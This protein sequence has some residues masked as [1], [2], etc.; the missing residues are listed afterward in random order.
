MVAQDSLA[1]SDIMSLFRDLQA[2]GPA[3]STPREASPGPSAELPDRPEPSAAALDGHSELDLLSLQP[4]LPT[5]SLPRTEKPPEWTA[6]T[7][8]ERIMALNP[9]A[10]AHFLSRFN[11][12]SLREYLEHL[13]VQ[14]EPAPE[15][16]E[17]RPPDQPVVMVTRRW[18]RPTGRPGILSREADA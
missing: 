6:G 14:R 5:E 7:L 11:E 13:L 15:A 2:R 10:S 16:G 3:P 18:V 1:T 4:Q 9:S 17:V 8:I 12:T